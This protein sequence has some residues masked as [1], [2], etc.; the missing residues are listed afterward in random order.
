MDRVVLVQL[1]GTACVISAGI[2]NVVALVLNPQSTIP[3]PAILLQIV[4]S[5][6]WST[7]GL[8]SGNH[9]LT[10]SSFSSGVIHIAAMVI[11][12]YRPTRKIRI[13]NDSLDGLPQL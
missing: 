13:L 1:S 10:L 4:G 7:Y 9:F 8:M 12:L 2:C 5:A 11:K 3:I 6:L